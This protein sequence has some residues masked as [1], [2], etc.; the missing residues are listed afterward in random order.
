MGR[1]LANGPGDMD[2]IY[3]HIIPKTLKWYL[4][5]PCLTLSNTRYILMVKWSNPGK[6]VASSPT[7]RCCSY[8]N[9]VPLVTLDYSHQLYFLQKINQVNGRKV[10]WHFDVTIF[11]PSILNLV[12][13]LL[14]FCANCFRK[15]LCFFL[16]LIY[17]RYY[18][19]DKLSEWYCLIR[20]YYNF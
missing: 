9:G 2:L 3:G 19:D 15:Y 8:W 6:G 16:L 13:N 7:P 14:L 1:V 11:I 4:I 18:M 10:D 5:P 12:F 20:Y 17:H